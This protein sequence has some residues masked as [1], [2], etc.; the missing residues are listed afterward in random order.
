MEDATQFP[1]DITY[2]RLII[3]QTL[4]VEPD[5]EAYLRELAELNRKYNRNDI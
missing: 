1:G 4:E 2:H 3:A 5:N